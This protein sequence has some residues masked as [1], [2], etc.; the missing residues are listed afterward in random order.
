MLNLTGTA[1]PYRGYENQDGLLRHSSPPPLIL[2][3]AFQQAGFIL[4]VNIRTIGANSPTSVGTARIV[5]LR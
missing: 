4:K 3:N 2:T 5:R 1:Q